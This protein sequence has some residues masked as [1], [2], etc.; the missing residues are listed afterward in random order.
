MSV[1]FRCFSDRGELAEDRDAAEEIRNHLLRVGIDQVT[2]Y[3]TSVDGLP[4]FV[5]RIVI[6]A[7]LEQFDAAMVLDVR[8]KTEHAAGHIPGSQQLSAGRVLWHQD[9]LSRSESVVTYCQT[10]VRNSVAA[11]ALRRA[12]HDVVELD[13]SFGGWSDWKNS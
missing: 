13:G 2:R 8:S 6:P 5:P 12:G 4:S 10:G 9:E 11:N 3:V 7:D 1:L